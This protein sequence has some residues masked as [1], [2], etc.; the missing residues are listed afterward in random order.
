MR[1]KITGPGP[2]KRAAR[3]SKPTTTARKA[4]KRSGLPVKRSGPKFANQKV[5]ANQLE[6]RRGGVYMGS[7]G[8][9]AGTTAG[10]YV[11]K[12][13]NAKFKKPRKK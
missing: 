9:G 11:Q 12:P 2:A 5:N 13:Y 10:L 1:R 4:V 6:D 3:N 7:P 8:Y